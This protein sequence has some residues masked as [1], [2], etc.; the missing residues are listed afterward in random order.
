MAKTENKK[1]TEEYLNWMM[2][3][4]KLITTLEERI[5]RFRGDMN[6]DEYV[7][8]LDAFEEDLNLP[9]I[10]SPLFVLDF[11]D[12]SASKWL[13]RLQ[14]MRADLMNDFCDIIPVPNY[15]ITKPNSANIDKFLDEILERKKHQ[16]KRLFKNKNRLIIEEFE[17]EMVHLKMIKGEMKVIP[18][19]KKK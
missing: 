8:A 9:P 1:T 6:D 15:K 12:E 13:N 16:A 5:D 14:I 2:I 3:L 18:T 7:S 11:N 4:D 19:D 10:L 17:K